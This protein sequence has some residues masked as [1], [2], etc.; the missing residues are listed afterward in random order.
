L[1]I[2]IDVSDKINQTLL[3]TFKIVVP[4]TAY[5]SMRLLHSYEMLPATQTPHIPLLISA[6]SHLLVRLDTSTSCVA[7]Q[8]RENILRGTEEGE[9]IFDKPHARDTE[10]EHV[11]VK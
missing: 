11:D 3:Q 9:K 6:L 7:F 1:Y 10:E 5:L 8:N 2:H 4:N